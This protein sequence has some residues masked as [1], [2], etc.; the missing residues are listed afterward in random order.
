MHSTNRTDVAGNKSSHCCFCSMQCGLLLVPDDDRNS[1]TVKP[2]SDF[3]VATGRLCQKGLNS[4]QHVF[5]PS[6][7][8][9]PLKWK[10]TVR[11]G[12]RNEREPSSWD[13]ALNDIAERIH[14]IQAAHGKDAA[15]VYGGGSITNEMGYL[16]GKFTRVALGSKYIDYNGRYCMSS[17]AAAANQAFGIDRGMT[18]P[19]SE[20]P[21]AKF[22]ILAGTNIAECQP[23]MMAY[24][25]EAKKNQAVIV[26]IDPRN[27]L[28]SKLADIHVRLQ[29]G[30]DSVFVNGL[31]HVIVNEKLYD[32]DFVQHKTQGWAELTEAVKSYTPARVEEITG[33]LEAVT[34]T[35]AR[36]FAKAP[37]GIVLTARGLEQ[38]INGV[39]HALNYINLCLITGKLGK[40][41]C[42]FGSVTGQANGQGGREHGQKADQLPGYRSIADPDARRHV[43]QVWGVDPDDIPG[44][45]VSAYEMIE[46]IDQGE[47]KALIVLGSNPLVSSPNNRFVEKALRK[48]ELLVVIDLF[49]TETAAYAHWLLPGSSFLE[50]EGTLTN[51]EGRVFH[52]A[53]ALDTPGE[54]MEDY[55]IICKLAERLGRGAYFQYSGIEEVFDELCRASAGGRADYAGLSYRRLI[56]ESGLFWPCPAPDHPGTPLLFEDGFNH[57]DGKARLFGIRPRMPAEPTDSEYPYVLTTGRLASHYLSGA[58]T[59]RSEG[60]NRRAPVPIAEIHPWIAERLGLRRDSRIRLTSRRGSLVFDVK[61][62]EGIQPNTIFVPFHWGGELSINQLTN[63]ALHPVS[64]MPEFKICAVKAECV[65]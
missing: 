40:P 31:L 59:R 21:G 6:R 24:L 9:V 52:R 29:P 48:L 36:G 44:P 8:T 56:E 1:Y 4:I 20:I 45:G 33:V 25:A 37:T 41:G 49:E 51:L 10:A 22:I 34:R 28:T 54:C 32:P 55:R 14:G 18:M 30:F 53:K 42:G 57:P 64:R 7:I 46:K 19:L 12:E 38:Q 50:G 60:L 27:T 62:T 3:P 15:A 2:R 47:I 5:H 13:E 35:I 43:A 58:Q 16:L 17:A 26:T 65:D 63:D 11:S 61:V 39:E 23:T